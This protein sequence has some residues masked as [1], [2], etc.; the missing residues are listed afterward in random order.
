MIDPIR[1]AITAAEVM[2]DGNCSERS[3]PY[4]P[5]RRLL[6]LSIFYEVADW[7]PEA[8]SYLTAENISLEIALAHAG[9]FAVCRCNFNG[10]RFEFDGDGVPAAV[11]EVLADDAATPIDLCAWP[12]DLPERFATALGEADLIGITNVTNPATFAGGRPLR[13][14]RTP[15]AWLKAGCQGC[16][17]LNPA[18]GRHWLPMAPGKLLAESLE[19]GRALRSM[20]GKDFDPNRLLVPAEKQRSA[21]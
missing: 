8:A 16:A 14:W 20:L 7:S 18:G 3:L 5:P 19:H 13:V 15:L 21:A 9:I 6:D 2:A 4:L 12:L 1:K 11:V 17:V 10:R